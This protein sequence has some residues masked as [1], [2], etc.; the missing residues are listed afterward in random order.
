MKKIHDF[1]ERE[2]ERKKE[3]ERERERESMLLSMLFKEKYAY[4]FSSDNLKTCKLYIVTEVWRSFVLK[5][6]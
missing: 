5:E 1:K 6:C 4:Q 2:R 3:R